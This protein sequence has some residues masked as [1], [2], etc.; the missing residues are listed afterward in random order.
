[1]A[2]EKLGYRTRQRKS[3]DQPRELQEKTSGKER[4][5]AKVI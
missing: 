3:W 5:K 1:M 4:A 2:R